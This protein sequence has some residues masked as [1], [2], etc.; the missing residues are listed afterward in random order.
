MDEFMVVTTTG[1][2]AYSGSKKN[3]GI[4]RED[5]ERHVAERNIKAASSGYIVRY[6]V[7]PYAIPEK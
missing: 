7:A 1:G 2:V 6:E 4:S 3:H 5:A